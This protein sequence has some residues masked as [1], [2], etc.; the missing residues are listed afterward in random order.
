[1]IYTRV[2]RPLLGRAL[3]IAQGL[4]SEAN[5]RGWDVAPVE[6]SA[7]GYRAGA[8]IV[9]GGHSYRIEIHEQT[10]TLPFTAEDIAQWR[11]EY[12]WRDRSAD[13]P[14]PQRKRKRATGR[15]RLELP[16]G[17]GGGRANWTEGPRGPLEH[18]LGSVFDALEE[19]AAEDHHRDIEREKAVAI[20]KR[21]AHERELRAAAE[22]IDQSRGQRLAG[23]A[24]SWHAAEQIRR[25]VAALRA[26]LSSLEPEE[27]QRLQA[28]CDWA[29]Q[30]AQRSDPVV[31][32]NLIVGLNDQ[33][34]Q[35]R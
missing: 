5:R 10:Q 12:S 16:N 30:Q 7:Y 14:P 26:R 2:S 18:T 35:A 33:P 6:K 3:R 17:Y 9:I 34:E 25:Y 1:M 27:R 31:T 28:W 24:A 19:R 4:I 23:E 13:T 32:T 29:E 21:E 8:A 11:S 20:R 15:L 22:Q